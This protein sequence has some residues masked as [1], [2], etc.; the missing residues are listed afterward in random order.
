[1]PL[2]VG[3]AVYPPPLLFFC[4]DTPLLVAIWFILACA[5]SSCLLKDAVCADDSWFED[6]FLLLLVEELDELDER[7]FLVINI[8]LLLLI[9]PFYYVCV[10][11]KL[12]TFA[13]VQTNN[14]PFAE[15]A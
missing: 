10:P 13:A 14:L 7:L 1:M 8:Y 11:T 3:T 9:I 4:R 12:Q 5:P 15:F 6:V 2:L